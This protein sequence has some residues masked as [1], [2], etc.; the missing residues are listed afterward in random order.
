MLAGVPFKRG[1]LL[2][3]IDPRPMQAAVRQM[4]ANVA[5]DRAQLRQAEA[6]HGQ[7]QAEVTQSLA[8]LERD[9]AQLELARVQEQRYRSLLEKEF[10]AREQYEQV[11]RDLQDSSASP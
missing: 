5:K 2:F 4:E 11:K 1:D 7:R 3:T 8:N 10:I 6:A 9:L